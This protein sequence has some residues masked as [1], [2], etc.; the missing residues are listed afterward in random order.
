MVALIASVPRGVV[1]AV[2]VGTDVGVG[3]GVDI[4]EDVQPLRATIAKRMSSRSRSR[5][6]VLF[7]F[8]F[9]RLVSCY[10]S[11]VKKIDVPGSQHTCVHCISALTMLLPANKAAAMIVP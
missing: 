8:L 4:D 6:I 9:Y 2:P 1:D 11:L 3:A 5:N 7:S 10:P